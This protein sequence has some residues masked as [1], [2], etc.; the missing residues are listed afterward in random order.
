MLDEEEWLTVPLMHVPSLEKDDFLD[1][2]EIV[3]C[4]F[5]A[6]IPSLQKDDLLDEEEMANCPFKVRTFAGEG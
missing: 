1:E 4:L 5:K 2:E 6:S 3:N